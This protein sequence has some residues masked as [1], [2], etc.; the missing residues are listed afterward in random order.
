MAA[1]LVLDPPT[2]LHEHAFDAAE[3]LL[4]PVKHQILY[5]KSNQ[6]LS[7]FSFQTRL[8]TVM[9]NRLRLRK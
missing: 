7:M 4:D 5:T 1:A 2:T 8:T 6:A 3:A 9:G